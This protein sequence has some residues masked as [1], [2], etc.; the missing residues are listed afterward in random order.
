MTFL[1]STMIFMLVYYIGWFAGRWTLRRQITD[2]QQRL[3]LPPQP[4]EK[5]LDASKEH[6]GSPRTD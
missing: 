5:L 3:Q 2:A 6:D 1:L 4:L